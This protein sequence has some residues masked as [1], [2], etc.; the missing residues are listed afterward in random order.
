MSRVDRMLH[1]IVLICYYHQESLSGQRPSQ[2]ADISEYSEQ[3]S[4]EASGFHDSLF[5]FGGILKQLAAD[6]GLANYNQD[7]A[8]ETLLKNT[9]NANK[10]FLSSV[11]KYAYELPAVGSTLGPSKSNPSEPVIRTNFSDLVVYEIKCILDEILDAVENLTDAILN[12]IAPLYR[13]LITDATRTACNSGL[14]LAN[15]CIML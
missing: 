12:D 7:D 4:A 15:L 10:D 8:L 13:G 3:T 5:G 14:Q 1:L 11:D 9:V 2:Q 6:K